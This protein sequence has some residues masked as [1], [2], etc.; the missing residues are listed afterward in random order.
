MKWFKSQHQEA[1]TPEAFTLLLLKLAGDNVKD[2]VQFLE[3]DTLF[4]D[5]PILAIGTEHSKLP[6]AEDELMFFS[7]FALDYWI[8]NSVRTQEERDALGEALRAHWQNIFGGDP[9][10]QAMLDTLQER[11][12]AYGQII[13]EKKDDEFKLMGLGSKL[14]EFCGMPGF[15]VLVPVVPDLFLKAQISI[16]RLGSVRLKL[17]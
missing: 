7:Y 12:D 15:F 16:G 3:K 11:L 17:R 5:N 6:K 14:S 9:G 1:V 2:T 13:N 4:Q 8:Q 10:G